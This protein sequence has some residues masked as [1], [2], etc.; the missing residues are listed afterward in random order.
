MTTR[1]VPAAAAEARPRHR[2]ECACTW[3]GYRRRP[4]SR[5]CPSCAAPAATLRP[6]WLAGC[7]PRKGRCAYLAHI[8]P[9][10]RHAEH[11]GGFT[12]DLPT[13]WK[14]HLAG[15]YDPETHRNRGKG[16]RL[17]AAALDAGC[18][19]ELVRVWYGPQARQ[20]EQRLKQRRKPGACAPAPVA[21]S[22]RC[23]RSATATPTGT[24]RSSRRLRRRRPRG[25]V[26]TRRCGTPAGSGIWPSPSWPTASPRPDSR[27]HRTAVRT[28]LRPRRVATNKPHRQPTSRASCR[29][30]AEIPKLSR[31]LP[32][33]A[34]LEQGRLP[35]DRTDLYLRYVCCLSPAQLAAPGPLH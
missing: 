16:A 34:V 15:G 23:A 22:S 4:H 29:F 31:S 9:P 6:V 28:I 32:A 13:R 21:A 7:A 35:N 8:S 25:S 11:Y 3:V 26:T 24:T 30:R 19:I 17:L 2:V 10:Y 20:L 27:P 14:D 12:T 5:P 18:Q 33:L 1:G